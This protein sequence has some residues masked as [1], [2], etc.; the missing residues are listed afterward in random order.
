MNKLYL[1]FALI[2][3]FAVV[4][5]DAQTTLE[6]KVTDAETGE[7]ILFGN[8][9]LYRG[10]N[11]VTGTQ[12][13]FDGNYSFTNIDPGTYDVEASYVG[14][15]PQRQ[16]GVLITAGRANRL[17]IELTSGVMIDEIEVKTIKIE[18]LF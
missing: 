7:P 13:D 18:S 4:S 1:L 17:D 3:T 10:G 8:V 9:A 11:L 2:M 5:A 14:Y 12:T 16:T 15:T 6:G